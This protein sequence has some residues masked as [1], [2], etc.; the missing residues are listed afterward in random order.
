MSVSFLDLAYE[1]QSGEIFL[2]FLQSVGRK[3]I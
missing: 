3:G 2:A 1:A